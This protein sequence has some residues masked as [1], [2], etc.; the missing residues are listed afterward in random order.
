MGADVAK[1]N[2]HYSFIYVF[3]DG[4]WKMLSVLKVPP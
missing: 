1:V 3:E 4:Q 2:G